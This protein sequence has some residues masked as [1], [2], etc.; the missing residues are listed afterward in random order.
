MKK[1]MNSKRY[2]E[3][4]MNQ[5][6]ITEEEIQEIVEHYTDAFYYLKTI[7]KG[8]MQ[9]V[10]LNRDLTE[11]AAKDIATALGVEITPKGKKKFIF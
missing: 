2:L 4:D 9:I 7:G 5:L 1:N 6:Q 8:I 10:F 11:K 3:L